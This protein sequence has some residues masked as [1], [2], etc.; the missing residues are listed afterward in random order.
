MLKGIY[1][2]IND[3]DLEMNS[4]YKELI[5]VI[6]NYTVKSYIIVKYIP[7]K[8]PSHF[9]DITQE[10]KILS[11]YY[12]NFSK[13]IPKITNAYINK[14]P[15]LHYISPNI[16]TVLNNGKTLKIGLILPN[17]TYSTILAVLI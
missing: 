3:I 6:N 2:N 13:Y 5:E 15:I 16:S 8:R 7:R 14:Y 10:I 1:A 4:C 9:L 12:F 17:S 11:Y